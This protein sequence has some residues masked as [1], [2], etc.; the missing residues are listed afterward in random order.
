[1]RKAREERNTSRGPSKRIKIDG[2]YVYEYLTRYSE[3]HQISLQKM[4]ENIGKGHS[5]ISN[6]TY[7]GLLGRAELIALSHLYGLDVKRALAKHTKRPNF[8]EKKESETHRSSNPHQY[9]EGRVNQTNDRTIRIEILLILLLQ[10]LGMSR[11][12]I[13]RKYK[14]IK[15]K[16]DEKSLI[17][18][19]K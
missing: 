5:F 12:D 1:M 3:E 2:A 19:L 8:V 4:N 18:D 11:E 10:E 14:D 13:R 17:G 15:D 16:W 9:L 6:A 7:E